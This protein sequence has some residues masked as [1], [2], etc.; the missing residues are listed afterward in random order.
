[1]CDKQSWRDR[2]GGGERGRHAANQ[3]EHFVVLIKLLRNDL[4]TAG[5]RHEHEDCER[6]SLFFN[7]NNNNNK[8]KKKENAIKTGI[9]WE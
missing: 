9:N 4:C 5:L 6:I 2:K 1:M 8:R 3:N 7:N